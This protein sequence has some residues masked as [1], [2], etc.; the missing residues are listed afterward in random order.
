[1]HQGFLQNLMLSALLSLVTACGG[2][3]GGNSA[4]GVEPG[5]PPPGQPI[6]PEP[7]PPTPSDNPYAEQ[8]VLN[9]YITSAT[10]NADNQP[11]IQF[12]LSDR[13]TYW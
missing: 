11:V 5:P 10:L 9:A 4:P 6:P 1:M 7:I 8:T 3:G 12:Q 2:G 13:S